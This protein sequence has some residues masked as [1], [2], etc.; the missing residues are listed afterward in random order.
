[1]KRI[2]LHI[3]LMGETGVGKDTF[4]ATFPGPR[5]VW[6][7]DGHGQDM[8][9]MKNAQQVGELLSY[10]MGGHLVPYRDIIAQDGSV[11]RIEY[12]SSDNPLN[13]TA[14]NILESRMVNFTSEQQQWKTL[15]AG[16][17]SSAALENRLYEQFV[18]NP[19]FKDPRKWYGAATEYVERLVMMQ[20]A[21]TCNVIFICHVGRSLDEVGGEMLFTPDLPG[22]LSYGAGRYFNEMY[23]IYIPYREG[24]PIVNQETGKTERYLQTDHDGRYQVKT[25]I[26]ADNPCYP[27]YESLWRKWDKM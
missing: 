6:H 22:R 18:L 23:R 7:M 27:H 20:K 8:P 2:P 16:S 26:E 14:S 1:M 19:Q 25:H 10:N 12:Y 17:L 9:Y 4:A 5:I 24:K 3:L 15:I 13:P 21:L 11:T